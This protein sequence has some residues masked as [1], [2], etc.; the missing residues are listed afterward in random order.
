MA[1]A[2][3]VDS[4]RDRNSVCSML[5]SSTQSHAWSHLPVSSVVQSV[6]HSRRA[7]VRAVRWILARHLSDLALP[8]LESGWLRSTVI[9]FSIKLYT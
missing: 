1:A 3:S 4:C 6:L 7:Q 8:S 5:S 9:H 2:D